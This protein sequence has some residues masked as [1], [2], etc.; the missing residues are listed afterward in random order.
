[1]S[2]GDSV[3]ALHL[4]E[5]ILTAA[6]A[7]SADLLEVVLD[8]TFS[9]VLSHVTRAARTAT[10]EDRPLSPGGQVKRP[11]DVPPAA[12]TKRERKESAV[13][14]ETWAVKVLRR[15]GEVVDIRIPKTIV[16]DDAIKENNSSGEDVLD[17]RLSWSSDT[18]RCVDASPVLLLRYRTDQSPDEGT[19]SVIIGS[20]SHRIQALDLIS[21]SLV[22]ERVLGGRIEASAAVSHCGS[23]VVVGQ[24]LDL[25][26]DLLSSK[27]APR[28]RVIDDFSSASSQVATTA[29]CISCVPHLETHGGFSRRGMQ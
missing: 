16:P 29:V 12:P 11:S 26:S 20:H 28:L 23:L 4:C 9:D 22:W 19:P 8:G 25:T 15:A 17:L 5:D 18:G 3:K 24:F 13:A 7:A 1:M 21:G 27:T 6:G 2:G 14:E 10:P